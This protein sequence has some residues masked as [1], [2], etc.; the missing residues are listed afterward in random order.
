MHFLK[1]DP[2][3]YQIDALRKMQGRDVFALF[4][5]VG[6][7]KTWLAL[8][9]IVELYKSGL[10]SYVVIVAPSGVQ[11]QWVNE[12]IPEHFP[13]DVD[14]RA[15]VYEDTGA[16]NKAFDALFEFK[17]LKILSVHIEGVNARRGRA[18]IAEF[19]QKSKNRALFIV[20]ESHLI[21]TPSAK[22]TQRILYF[23]K[24]SSYRLIMSGTPNAKSIYDMYSQFKFLDYKILGF[25]R[26]EDFKNQYC[27]MAM[28]PFGIEI[29]GAKNI[30]EFVEKTDPYVYRITADDALGLPPKV[31][32][33]RQFE[34]TAEQKRMIKDIKREWRTLVNQK[35]ATVKAG[36]TA[37]LR[38]QQITCGFLADNE[39]TLHKFDNPR[40]TALKDVLAEIEGKAI[41]WCRFHQ[42]VEAICRALGDKAMHYYGPTE[43]A[44]RELAKSEFLD[45]ASEV[46]YLVATPP[47][48]GTGLN[49]QGPCRY[50]I[51]YS[52]SFNN[53]DRIQSEGRTR[54]LGTKGSIIYIDLLAIGGIDKRLLNLLRNNRE[55]AELT[56]EGY[57][58]FLSLTDG[59]EKSKVSRLDNL[60][61]E[62]A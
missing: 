37:L 57:G 47:S 51:Y 14:Y 1:T 12:Q 13:D 8:N 41:I 26:S 3:E 48:M 49:L 60:N 28:T 4:M 23:G 6:T 56:L 50:N 46:Q 22:R 62:V 7:G 61:K 32:A 31:F 19:L 39:K 38:I 58:E 45:P 5:D 2:R 42:D 44:D 29:V 35:K 36:A 11:R 40:L 55:V 34:L 21:K 30:D 17:G 9:R 24:R 18:A 59:E 10:C 20:D 53:V 54:R 43:E 15:L 27:S 52:N 25:T 33:T 16:F